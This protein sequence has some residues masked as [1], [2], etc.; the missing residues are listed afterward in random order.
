MSSYLHTILSQRYSGISPLRML[1]TS[2][3]TH[4]FIP[5]EFTTEAT[6]ESRS[7]ESLGP[8]ECFLPVG[9]TSGKVSQ[10]FLE[11]PSVKGVY[12]YLTQ[13]YSSRLLRVKS[14]NNPKTTKTGW[15]LEFYQPVGRKEWRTFS[16]F[17]GINCIDYLLEQYKNWSQYTNLSEIL[18]LVK[19]NERPSKTHLPKSTIPHYSI[20]IGASGV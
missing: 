1:S 14:R 3:P 17:F 16:W 6:S 2:H 13:P 5:W 9:N 11:N 7:S 4:I 18:I 19:I 20:T 8:M 10:K 12:I 15:I